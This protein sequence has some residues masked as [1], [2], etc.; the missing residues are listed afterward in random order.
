LCRSSST[1]PALPKQEHA[2]EE[3]QK[4]KE[5]KFIIEKARV[6]KVGGGESMGWLDSWMHLSMDGWMDGWMVS[7][8]PLSTKD[9]VVAK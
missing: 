5:G 6:M 3:T 8:R 2:F 1:C 7:G 9:H 4:Y